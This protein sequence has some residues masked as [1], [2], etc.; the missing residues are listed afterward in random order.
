[1]KKGLVKF[2]LIAFLIV[3]MSLSIMASSSSGKT[4]FQIDKV[5]EPV[6]VDGEIKSEE[7]E[8]AKVYI[9]DNEIMPGDNVKAPVKTEFRMIYSET[10][11]YVSFKAFDKRPDEIR[12]HLSDRDKA[13]KDDL[14]G[15]TLDTF[16]DENR[17]FVF[18]SNPLGVQIDQIKTNGG[19]RGDSSWDGIWE[20]AG[21]ITE[22]GYEVEMVIPFSTLQFQRTKGNQQ[23]GFMPERIYPRNRRHKITLMKVDRNNSYILT[24]CPKIEGFRNISPGKNIEIAPTLTGLRAYS[25]DDNPDNPMKKTA[26]EMDFGLSGHWGF[27]PNLVFSGAVNP[28]FSQVEADAAQLDINNQFA[29]YFHEKRPFFLEGKD[30]FSTPLN[31]V[32]TR[33]VSTPEWGVKL[34]GKEGKNAIGFFSARD[35]VSTIMIPGV[36]GSST[37]S[38]AGKTQDTVVR[39][40]RDLKNAST[41]GVVITDREGSGYHNRVAGV[42]SVIRIGDADTI[43]F[44]TLVSNTKYPGDLAEEYS[45]RMGNFNGFALDLQYRKK[46][47]TY[48]YKGYYRHLSDKFRADLGFIP[49]VGFKRFGGEAERIWWGA[50][51]SFFSRVSVR[52]AFAEDSETESGDLMRREAEVFI[53]ADGPMQSWGT[54]NYTRRRMVYNDLAFDQDRMFLR[55][56]FRPTGALSLKYWLSLGNEID[57]GHTRAGNKIQFKPE[58]VWNPGKN[59]EFGFSYFY[60]KLNVDKRKLFLAQLFEAKLIYY[61]NRKTFFRCIVQYKDVERNTDLYDYEVD[62]RTRTVFTQLLFSYKLNP[63]TVFFLGYTSNYKGENQRIPVQMDQSLFL[64]IGYALSL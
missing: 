35:K 15:I 9:F 7:W 14:V 3:F 39:Y 21:R 16:N 56:G 10:A 49:Q 2:F 47:R 61:M 19:S 50:E 30:F 54:F 63:R 22:N 55:M 29:L 48:M 20:S 18:Y 38:I 27:T 17:C 26:S 34:S 23:W 33:T 57:Y 60:N 36:N 12:A 45:Q 59:F 62:S 44:Q 28:D 41:V 40:R 31:T 13:W 32:Y 25:R 64:K 5:D 58:L 46:K 1:M 53:S 6:V 37:T 11:L 51:D 43:T 8:G 4:V 52:A 24:Q 42:D